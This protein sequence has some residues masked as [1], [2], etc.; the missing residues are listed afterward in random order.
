M[1]EKH[2]IM[3]L[4]PAPASTAPGRVFVLHLKRPQEK[5]AVERHLEGASDT[6][7][8]ST[9]LFADGQ[10]SGLV[11]A[12]RKRPDTYN[13]RVLLPSVQRS[14]FDQSCNHFNLET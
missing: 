12:I 5:A 4:I 6:A 3:S 11:H 13:L 14:F 9:R 10:V 7:T 1:S 8:C 2:A